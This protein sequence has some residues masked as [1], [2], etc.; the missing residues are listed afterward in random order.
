MKTQTLV[1]TA[2]VVSLSSSAFAG[3]IKFEDLASFLGAVSSPLHEDFDAFGSGQ[4]VSALPSVNIG[5]IIGIDRSGVQVDTFVTAQA[6]LPFPMLGGQNTSSPPNL[7]SNDLASPFF[8]TGTIEFL[9]DSGMDALGFFVADGSALATFRIELYDGADLVGIINSDAPKNLPDSFL[10][11]T[12]S[13]LFDRA[14]IGSNQ[15]TDSWGIDDLYAQTPAPG[16]L[17][18]I[19]LAGVVGSRRRRV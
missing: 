16:A 13:T 9:F 4:I 8:A 10:G 5:N 2:A 15:L 11:V 18:L 12:S 6:D 3:L 17:G 1:V 14:I 19:A 7:F